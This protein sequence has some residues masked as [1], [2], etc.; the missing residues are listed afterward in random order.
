MVTGASS[1]IGAATVRQLRGAGFDVVAGARRADRLAELA[2]ETG[3]RVHALDVTSQASIDAFCDAIPEAAVLVNNAGGAL[4]L[5]PLAVAA[6]A[7]WTTMWETNVMGLMRM[8]RALLPKLTASGDGHIVNI[9]SIAG[10]EV[11]PGGAGYT[12]AKHAVRAL[13]QTLRIELGGLPVRVTEIDPGMVET[14]FSVVR[15]AVNGQTKG[16]QKRPNKKIP[17]SG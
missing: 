11:Y 16:Y 10:L 12:A 4:G 8:T 13:T 7:K 9:G 2:A 6:D 17:P 15:Y 5:E 3:A 14:E 1:G